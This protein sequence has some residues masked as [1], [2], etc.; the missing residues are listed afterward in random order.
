MGSISIE[1]W[2]SRIGAFGGSTAAHRSYS[3]E[4]ATTGS[5][6]VHGQGHFILIMAMLLV[7]ANITQMLLVQAGVERNPGPTNGDKQG[8]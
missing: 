7:Y 2:R 3:I 8:K 5:L 6:T 1:Q 4:R